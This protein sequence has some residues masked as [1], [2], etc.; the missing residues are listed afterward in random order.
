MMYC[1][2]S[3][4]FL[5]GLMFLFALAPSCMYLCCVRPQ[6]WSVHRKCDVLRYALVELKPELNFRQT[7]RRSFKFIVLGVL[8]KMDGLIH[9]AKRATCLMNSIRAKSCGTL[10]LCKFAALLRNCFLSV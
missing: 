9:F 5:P 10:F 3:S 8:E 7:T 6:N 4:Y 1:Y 2:Q